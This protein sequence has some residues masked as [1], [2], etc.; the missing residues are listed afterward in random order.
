MGLRFG[1]LGAGRIGRVHARAVH[2]TAGAE[3]AAVA[4]SVE[5]AAKAISTEYDCR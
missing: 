3:L 5:A 4:D 1:L 2:S